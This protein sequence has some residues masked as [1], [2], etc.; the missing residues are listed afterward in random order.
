MEVIQRSPKKTRGRTPWFFSSTERVSVACR[1]SSVRVS[2]HSCLPNRNGELAPIATCGPSS[3]CAAFQLAA[4]SCG[5]TCRCSCTDVHAA[6]GAMV[7]A[8]AVTRSGVV[9]EE[10]SSSR[11][12]P[13]AAKT[14]SFSAA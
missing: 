2:A 12:S 14:D 5:L 6:S 1:N 7:S 4:K 3:V 10:M 13:R 11:S 9:G 8:N